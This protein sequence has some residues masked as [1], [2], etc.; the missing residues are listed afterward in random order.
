MQ[1]ATTYQQR[2]DEFTLQLGQTES[3]LKQLSLARLLCFVGI[4]FFG[5]QYFRHNFGV[6]WLL[7]AA[8][9]LAGFVWSLVRYQHGKDHQALLQALLT[10]NRKEL[11]VVTEQVADFENGEMFIDD[12]HDFSGD[13]DVFGPSSLYQYLNRTGTLTGRQFL[14]DW[15]QRPQQNV[16]DIKAVQEAVRR[17]SGELEFRQ[18][19]TAHAQLAKEG[20][21]DVQEIR[22]WKEAPLQFLSRKTLR[23]AAYVMPVL[24]VAGIVYYGFSG[25]YVPMLL[26]MFVNWMILLGNVKKVNAQHMLLSNK[27]GLLKKFAALL[28][29]IKA[30]DWKGVPWLEARQQTA[31]EADR[32]LH[33]LA[34]ISNL[35]D[36]RLNLLVG[37]VLN[38]VMLYD[39]HCIFRLERWK[40]EH[41]LDV[42]EWIEVI[43]R[44]ETVGSLA[45]FAFNHPNY[46]YPEISDQPGVSGKAVGHPLIPEGECVVNDWNIGE[47][48]QFH[49]IT[50]S[51]MS[52]KSTFLRSVGVNWLLA[53][54]GAP[55]C[56]AEFTCHPLRIMTSMR[57]KDSIARHTSYFQAE[58]LRL[59]H[60]IQVLKSGQRVFIIL[61]EILKG[62]NSEDK[63]TGSRELIRHFLQYNC[64]GMIATHDLE[65]GGLEQEHPRQIRNYCFE[66]SLDGG[67]LHFDYK[68]RPGVARNKNATFLMKQMGII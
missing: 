16:A 47:G 3:R 43:A 12:Q 58:L 20:E 25:N 55:V 35:L 4:L 14:A 23:M 32:S 42:E 51:N 57:I 19:F 17:L 28:R 13:L 29:M 52:G 10:L 66:S 39:I 61:D 33:K 30:A 8:L 6:E 64:M 15:L 45:T 54:A 26:G 50:G 31:A 27:E 38:S 49:I 11:R 59:Q 21:N 62:T 2:I 37:F 18:L 53:M 22:L 36:Q 56:A 63:L 68:M 44:V 67:R 9:L 1:T 60:I 24:V 46:T 48:E 41:R 7:G 65:L 5:V 40:A 34:S